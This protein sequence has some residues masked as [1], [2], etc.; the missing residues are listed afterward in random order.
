VLL[1]F[2]VLATTSVALPGPP[3]TGNVSL[4]ATPVRSPLLGVPGLFGLLIVNVIVLVPFR[5][6]LVGL[7]AFAIVGGA[8]TVTVA[9]APVLAPPSVELTTTLLS[10]SPAVVPC[11]LTETAHDALEATVPPDRLTELEPPVAVPPH[12]LFRFGVEAT[13]RPAGRLSVKDSPVSD[14]VLFGFVMLMVNNVVP[15]NGILVGANVL[16]T[17]A[18]ATTVRVAVLLVAP[19]PPLVELTAPV[20]FDTLPATVPVTFTTMVQVVPGVAMLPPDRLMLVLFAAAVTVPLQV[21]LTPGVLATCNPPVKVSLKATP[22]SAV[23][24][25]AGLAMVKVTVVVPFNGMEAAP[26]ALEMV[27]GATIV[28][29]AVLLVVP[30]PPS[31]EVIAP[32]VFEASPAAT[33]F[34]STL[35][36]QEAL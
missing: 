23:V 10:L 35:R 18:G 30:V 14:T 12:V 20:V 4:K 17:V 27:G 21:L 13:T 34:T 24:L 33:P 28:S 25:A 36:V 29:G 5:G 16:V 8:T 3:L 26:K 15:F 11:T 32:V 31:V 1:T 22:L 6:M 2:G 7:N 9:L 19:V